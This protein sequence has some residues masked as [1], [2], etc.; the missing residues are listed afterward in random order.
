MFSLPSPPPPS[1]AGEAAQDFQPLVTDGVRVTQATNGS[2]V[3]PQ[4]TSH[5]AGWYLCQAANGVG[6]ALSKMAQLTVHGE[7]GTR[8]VWRYCAV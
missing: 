7:W 8:K 3:L 5:Q 4:V 2:L 1:P 6:K